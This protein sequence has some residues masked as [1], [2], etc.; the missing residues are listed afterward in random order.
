[1][2]NP[3]FLIVGAG[4]SGLASAYYLSLAGAAVTVLEREPGPGLGTSYANGGMLTPSMSDPWNSPQACRQLLGWPGRGK[5]PLRLRPAALPHY[6]SWGLKFLRNAGPAR[7]RAATQANLALA[8]L[9]LRELRSMRE[10]TDLRYAAAQR[11]TLKLYTD[12]AALALARARFETLQAHGLRFHAL[13]RAGVIGLEPL[14]ADASARLAGGIHYPDDETG[15]A[16]LFCKALHT[17]ALRRGVKFKFACEVRKILRSGDRIAGLLTDHGPQAG[18]A[19]V[20]AA[21][22]WSVALLE[23]LGLRVPIRP[24]K[25]YSLSAELDDPALMPGLAIIDDS[26]H[27]AMTPLGSTL[28]LAGTAELAGWNSDLDP[29]QLALLWNLVETLSPPTAA[30][31]DR[32]GA[33]SWCGFRPMAADGRPL[34]GPTRI[35]G[36]YL[37]T[38]HGH[39]GWT[40]AMG[41]GRLLAALA[42]EEDPPIPA[43]AFSPRAE[44]RGKFRVA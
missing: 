39:L 43:Q 36:L 6:M 11:G 1:M 40:Q 4:L 25:G 42:N 24:V 23:P 12:P 26:L 15:D 34:I 19:V 27:T 31:L 18:D 9:S 14:L 20:I 7:H 33:R 13:D 10:H 8:L 2:S 32:D 38:G 29:K 41:S 37:N 22:A 35:P 21:A 17:A 28:R 30:A 5:S 3:D 44:L 16:H